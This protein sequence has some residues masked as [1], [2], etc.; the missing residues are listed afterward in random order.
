MM[1]EF[2]RDAALDELAALEALQWRASTAW[3]DHRDQLTAHPDAISIPSA[4]STQHRVRVAWGSA[5]PVGFSVVPGY[6][7]AGRVPS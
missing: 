6:I 7:S 1:V 5:Q 4:A 2:I 3:D